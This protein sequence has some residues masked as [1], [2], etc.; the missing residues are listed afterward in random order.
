VC[1]NPNL[2]ARGVI[3]NLSNNLNYFAQTPLSNYQVGR[4]ANQVLSAVTSNMPAMPAAFGGSTSYTHDANIE[5]TDE[6]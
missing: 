2:D 1:H 5:L 6:T 3:S 4:A